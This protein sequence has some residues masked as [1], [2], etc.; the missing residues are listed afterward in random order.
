M[1][2]R[3]A[4]RELAVIAFSQIGKSIRKNEDINV[5]EVI[6]KST[7]ILT[8]EAETNL[9]SAVEELFEVKDF[10]RNY[11]FEHPVNVERSYEEA[12]IP[13]KI[14]LT[15]DMAGRIDMILEAAEKTY[16]AI[17]LTKLTSLAEIE[18]VK[19]YAI[20]IVKTFIENREEIDNKIKEYSKGWDVSRL[21]KIDRDILRIAIAEILYFEDVPESVS[22]D[23]AVEL[24]KKY[25]EPESSKFINGIL[26]QMVKK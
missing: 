25:S 7:E 13:V 6:Q 19:E 18:K 2:K 21:I 5:A 11:E 10:I 22:I 12:V 9:N 17:E 24:A 15:S 3:R 8:G 14:P 4:A 20:K 23:E 1:N 16:S 26:A